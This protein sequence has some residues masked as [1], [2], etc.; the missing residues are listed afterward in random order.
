M[1]CSI[2]NVNIL[3]VHYGENWLRGSE[4]VLLDQLKLAQT[5]DYRPILW[6]NSQ[7]LANKARTLGIEVIVDSFVCLAYWTTPRW[8]FVAYTKQIFRAYA[9][10]KKYDIS[11]VHCNNGAPCQWMAPVCKFTQT[12]LLLHLH[13][14]YMYRDRL[15][16]LFYW[17]DRVIGVSNAV[18]SLMH[19]G[20]FEQKRLGVI[21]NG[22]SPERVLSPSPIDLRASIGASQTDYVLLYV[23]SLIP[24]KS[25]QSLINAVDDLKTKYPV[26]LVIV[27]NGSDKGRLVEL[28]KQLNLERIVFFLSE[29][30]NVGKIY[31]SDVNCFVSPTLE[32]VF[33]LTLAEASIAKIP[34]V[35]TDVPGVNEIYTADKNALLV[36]ANNTDMLYR[37]VERLINSP[38]LAKKLADAA[39]HHIITKFTLENQFCSFA[40]EYQTLEGEMVKTG[41]FR[42][43]I[44]QLRRLIRALIIKVRHKLSTVYQWHRNH[45]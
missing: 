12:P 37:A 38:K 8:N 18:I 42:M 5:N 10:I 11:V 26:K 39:N 40:K 20:E 35:T 32:E 30:E 1:T 36:P 19:D 34:V 2:G 9:L 13:A 14:R 33:G 4:I 31:S 22:V 29:T 21:Y 28:T 17:A 43:I 25:I 45:G 7:V 15:T 3:Y 27:G 23:G 41:V 44:S 6:C 24:R 16:L